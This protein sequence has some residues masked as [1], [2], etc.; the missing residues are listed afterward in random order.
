MSL[1]AGVGLALLLAAGPGV[2]GEAGP[3]DMCIRPGT[4]GQVR[5]TVQ[6]GGQ[7]TPI[8]DVAVLAVPASSRRLS[9]VADPASDRPAWL[10]QARTGA[11][12]GLVL[13]TPPGL[14][15]LVIVA[16]GFERFEAVI[17][18]R[19]GAR[20]EVKL[21]PR[22]LELNPYRTVVRAPTETARV[23]DVAA[24]T[25]SREEI[26]TLPGSQGDPL[27]A[28][29]NLPGVARTPGGLGLLV[30]RGASPNQSQVFVGEH[31]VPR[32]FHVLSLASV[33]P[34]D[35]IDRIDF[36]PGNFDS[37]YGNATG[38][39]VV[40]E[41]R[42]GRRDGMHGFA[43]L[44]LAAASALIEGPV[45][46]RGGSVVVAAQRAYVDGVLLAA[47]KLLGRQDLLLPRYWDYQAMFD[48]PLRGGGSI[49]ARV[50]GSGDRIRL[51]GD[52]YTTGESR[53]VFD[54]RSDF[55]RVDVVVRKR[56]GPWRFMVSPAFRFQ[57]GRSDLPQQMAEQYRR[58][59]VT[60]L[61]AEGVRAI[62]ERLELVFGTDMQLDAYTAQTIVL[63]TTGVG[64]SPRMTQ[65][66]SGVETWVG[67]Y[68]TGRLRLGPLLLTPGVRASGFVVGAA[69]AFAVDPRLN[70]RLDVAERWSLRAGI[71]LYSQP[72]VVRYAA[73]GRIVP[74]T[75]RLG[76][77]NL[78]VPAF[79]SNFEPVVT[80]APVDDTLRVS[81]ALQASATVAHEL[82]TGMSLE[83]TG[84]WREQDNAVPPQIDGQLLPA[85]TT[86]NYGLEV[87]LRR[88]L[89]RRLY[90]W[91][92]YTAMRSQSLVQPLGEELGE[93]YPADFD[94][95]H[96]LAV[97]VSVKLRHGWQIG[98]RFR[99]VSGTPYTPLLGSLQY[100]G[101]FQAISGVYNSARFPPFHQLDLRVDRRW[102]VRRASVTA[103]LDVQNVYNHNN[104]EAYLYN[105]DYSSKV[106]GIGL[107]IFP[108]IGVRVDY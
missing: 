94:Q 15:R 106:G 10:R 7:R 104:V 9:A 18:V 91:L 103:Y 100:E 47:Q 86:R 5:G 3:A 75:A 2:A 12:G 58:D 89:T 24:R 90:G 4:C 21:Y 53:L 77:D 34:A 14:V 83:L 107:P 73:D 51:R 23:P 81:R 16:P 49:S 85:V 70:A 27:R 22:P 82:L 99:L 62:A 40:I 95:R 43:E 33:V 61:R 87:L 54:F 45:G 92:A 25:L 72:R 69:R 29:Q 37:R 39:V 20:T 57:I 79:F 11:D 84:F 31:P 26:A 30:L 1:G 76:T 44:D 78:V 96:N 60:S 46:K 17:E 93:R 35:V 56:F 32:A 42:R 102:I 80:F 48:H 59:Y 98:G 97:I 52:D 68:T 105:Y 101:T 50:I 71:G 88:P 74:G 63:N 6:A 41:P 13:D 65:N 55:H 8:V 36:V 28:L 66:T 108:S 67:A 19:A 38:G 64:D